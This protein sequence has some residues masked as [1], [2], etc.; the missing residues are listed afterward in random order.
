MS[1]AT[2]AAR[3]RQLESDNARLRRALER[4]GVSTELRHQV[5]NTLAMVRAILRRSAETNHSVA[6]YAAHLEGR[7]DAILRVQ[8]MIGGS[9]IGSVPLHDLVSDELHKH[10]AS[11]GEQV[12]LTGPCVHLQPRTAELMALAIYELT[13]NALEHGVLM[14]PCG[15][16]HASWNVTPRQG[17]IGLTFV[18]RESGSNRSTYCVTRRRGFGTEVLEGMLSYEL[19]AQIHQTF[20]P[21]GLCCKIEFHLPMQLGLVVN[22]SSMI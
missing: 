1:D 22:N 4:Q 21:E 20:E 11:E 9:A 14:R 6:D 13:T 15:R 10:L 7:L 17:R 16:I 2:L 18:W 5:R 3:I 8:T 12:R 19:D